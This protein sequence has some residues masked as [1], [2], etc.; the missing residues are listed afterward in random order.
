MT[1][2]TAA[3]RM[4]AVGVGLMAVLSLGACGSGSSTTA[5][6]AASSSSSTASASSSTPTDSSSSSS[7]SSVALSATGVDQCLVGSWKSTMV[8]GTVTISGTQYT[9]TG[10]AGE[11]LII[12]ADG[13]YAD[14][15]AGEQQVTG[16]GGG[17]TVV[18]TNTGADSGTIVAAAQQVT[19]KPTDPSTVTQTVQQDGTTV[20]TTHPAASTSAQYGCNQGGGFTVTTGGG[21][22]F[23]YMPA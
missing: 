20:S 16:T 13:T 11:S 17:H 21:L 18:I 14:D 15:H 8:T 9:F 1:M 12:K 23:Q 5:S 2:L 6:T 7:T 10:G 3:R 4:A 22:A 19:I